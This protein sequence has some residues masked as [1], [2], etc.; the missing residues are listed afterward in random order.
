MKRPRRV[1][2]VGAI[3]FGLVGGAIYSGTAAQEMPC[4]DE[5]RTLCADV[6]PGG[7]RILQCLKNNEAKLPMVC[8]Q[9]LHDLERAASGPLAACRDDWVAYCYHPR[10]STGREEMIQCLQANQT[11]V[12]SSCQK[13]MQEQGSKRRQQRGMMP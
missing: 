11:K 13:A 1:V 5:V 10:A 4:T 2:L 12:S 6:Q 9:R 8:V 3:A 7:G